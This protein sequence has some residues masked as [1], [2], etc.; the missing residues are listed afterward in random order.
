MWLLPLTAAPGFAWT[1]DINTL[2]ER[3]PILPVE[4]APVE[5]LSLSAWGCMPNGNGA[6]SDMIAGSCLTTADV[7]ETASL[8]EQAL[9]PDGTVRDHVKP[10]ARWHLGQSALGNQ[11]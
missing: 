2:I 7:S 11:L 10:E 4:K 3:L 8:I 1:R 9:N 6:N 5:N